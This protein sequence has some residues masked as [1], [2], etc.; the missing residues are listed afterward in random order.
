M[1]NV[2][3][4]ELKQMNMDIYVNLL[5]IKKAEKTENKELEY[6]LVVQEAKLQALGIPTDN[7]KIIIEE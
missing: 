4:D 3:F 5:R 2:T 7:L 1:R 6:Q